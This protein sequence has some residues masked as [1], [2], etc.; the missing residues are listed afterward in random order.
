MNIEKF[1]QHHGLAENPFEAEEARHDAVFHRLIDTAYCHPDF[2]KIL[3]RIDQPS[4]AVVFGEKGVGKSSI[5]HGL[6]N[7]THASPRHN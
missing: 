3:G 7:N 6:A 1:L 4:T 5:L 2:A